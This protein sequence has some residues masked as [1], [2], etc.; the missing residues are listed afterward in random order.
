M[1]VNFGIRNLYDSKRGRILLL[2]LGPLL[3]YLE[4]K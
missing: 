1:E 2:R 4:C 3:N